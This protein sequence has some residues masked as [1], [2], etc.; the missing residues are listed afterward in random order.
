MAYPHCITL[1][2]SIIG[3][4][5]KGRFSLV[6]WFLAQKHPVRGFTRAIYSGLTTPELARVVADYVL[7]RADLRG[8]YH[9]SVDPINKYDLLK[10]IAEQY[11]VDTPIEPYDA[12]SIDR[13]LD[14]TR[15]REATGYR[16]PSWPELC[17]TM[18]QDYLECG[19]Y[20]EGKERK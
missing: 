8:L 19:R 5:L 1:R 12:V 4:E 14:S 13:S 6:E 9:L 18:R 16:P 11:E 20:P 15:F 7:P 10:L 17:R 2:T 3:H